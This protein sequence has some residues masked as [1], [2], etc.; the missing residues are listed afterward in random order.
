M[1]ITQ[2]TDEELK[3]LK[4]GNIADTISYIVSDNSKKAQRQAII[5]KEAELIRTYLINSARA[6]DYVIRITYSSNPFR[7]GLASLAKILKT[8]NIEV[9]EV[10]DQPRCPIEGSKMQ[11]LLELI[12][13]LQRNQS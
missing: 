12:I 2:I 3:K 11:N 10:Y 4:C 6:M 5:E 7:I 1:K 13:Y 9:K 8:W